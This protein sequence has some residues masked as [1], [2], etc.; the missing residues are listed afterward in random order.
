MKILAIKARRLGDTVLWTSALEALSSLKP[1]RLDIAYS[2]FYEELFLNDTRFHH[3]YL[4]SPSLKENARFRKDW[5]KAQY[6][7]VLNFHASPST[8]LLSSLSCAKEKVI[9]YHDRGGKT[10]TGSLPIPNLGQPMSAIER[11]LN[12]VRAMGWSGLSPQTKILFHSPSPVVKKRI[13]FGLGASRPAKQ[14]SLEYFLRAARLLKDNYEV[15]FNYDSENI[16]KDNLFLKKELGNYGTFS[17][18]KSLKELMQL[19]VTCELYVGPDSGVKHLA[20]ALGTK[21]LTLFGPESIGEW[22]GYDLE[23]HKTMQIDMVCR[24]EDSADKK[25]AWC[26]AYRCPH[27][28]HACMNLILPEEVVAVIQKTL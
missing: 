20:I 14:Y 1:E 13:I 23:M 6:D 17:H 18:T 21:T 26:G 27:G 12:V 2:K 28:S 24:D 7:Y 19:L 10:A 8:S 9:H 3:Q 4:L 11:D 15:I 25:F 22:H 16:F 5:S